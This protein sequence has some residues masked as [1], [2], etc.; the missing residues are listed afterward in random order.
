M[1]DKLI[2]D[3]IVSFNY[4]SRFINRSFMEAYSWYHNSTND[5]SF[6]DVVT[7][8]YC[9]INGTQVSTSMFLDT[10]DLGDKLEVVADFFVD[11]V[12]TASPEEAREF[13]N[14]V[15]SIIN[16][17]VPTYKMIEDDACSGDTMFEYS[18]E[19]SA[20]EALFHRAMI[21]YDQHPR[22]TFYEYL[23]KI[24]KDTGNTHIEVTYNSLVPED[25]LTDY[26]T[27]CNMFVA[28][29]RVFDY[30]EDTQIF[31]AMQSMFK[32][33]VWVSPYNTIPYEIVEEIIS[34]VPE[35]GYLVDKHLHSKVSKKSS[36]ISV[37]ASKSLYDQI[38]GIEGLIK[39]HRLSIII[40]VEKYKRNEHFE[41]YAAAVKEI[42]ESDPI[43]IITDYLSDDGYCQNDI[44]NIFCKRL[45]TDKVYEQYWSYPL[46]VVN[47]QGDVFPDE[48]LYD[49]HLYGLYTGAIE[50]FDPLRPLFP[51]II[52]RQYDL[53]T[54]ETADNIVDKAVDMNLEYIS[55]IYLY[56]HGPDTSVLS[57]WWFDRFGKLS[58]DVCL[59]V[60]I[61][62][63]IRC[64]GDTW[65]NNL[66]FILKK[67]MMELD[68][69]KLFDTYTLEEVNNGINVLSTM[70]E[71]EDEEEDEDY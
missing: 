31:T 62:V 61:M 19:C 44:I 8:Y 58:A 52:A 20:Y 16:H 38:T 56:I 48:S 39:Y 70:Y 42:K 3:K 37:Y 32:S 18:V 53:I 69:R 9:M 43:E 36:G 68:T 40:T 51:V 5:A 23:H 4:R 35:Y 17:M 41:P 7:A 64:N 2:I 50:T 67:M 12:L 11:K 65:P 6:E 13:I 26:R 10:Y 60:F 46:L 1:F 28:D 29:E 55:R 63:T 27:F 30:F 24:Y 47:D 33:S 59:E 45:I 34:Y 25:T 15:W 57:S 54:K 21:V 71:R 14:A 49:I 66:G 22:G